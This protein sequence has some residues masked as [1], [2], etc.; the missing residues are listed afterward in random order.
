MP[1]F[2]SPLYPCTLPVS[3]PG[4]DNVEA[5][6]MVHLYNDLRRIYTE[7]NK[8]DATL[9]RQIV[10]KYDGI[11]LVS[12]DDYMVGF[13]NVTALDLLLH[14]VATYGHITPTELTS[15]YN[16]MTAPN[17]TQ[18]LV[19][20]LFKKIDNGVLYAQAIQHPYHE[21]HYVNIAFIFILN[22]G[23]RPEAIRERK[24]RT[25]ENQMWAQFNILFA[26]VHCEHRLIK[27]TASQAGFNQPRIAVGKLSGLD[28]SRETSAALAKRD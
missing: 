1:P 13:A 12:V 19:E 14:L 10:H 3:S 4:M 15:N 25:I 22:T 7:Y 20:T 26:N 16:L 17:D 2:T 11:Y 6:G 18:N 27:M 21:A 28:F 5:N 9:K 8:V 24:R 23:D